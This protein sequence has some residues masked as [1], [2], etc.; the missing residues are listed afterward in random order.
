VL[1]TVVS[2]HGASRERLSHREYVVRATTVCREMK[3]SMLALPTG[4]RDAVYR[5]DAALIGRAVKKLRQLSPSPA[6]ER[7]HVVLT[8]ALAYVARILDDYPPL[9]RDHAETRLLIVHTTSGILG[10]RHGCGSG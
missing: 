9:N 6:D 2:V 4:S 7:A 5:R 10:I 8:D 3:G 1:L